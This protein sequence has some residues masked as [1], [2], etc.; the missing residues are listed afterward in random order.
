MNQYV[1]EQIIGRGA[2]GT[3]FLCSD[4]AR[5]NRQCI[6]KEIPME[7]VT[8]EERSTALNE[9]QILKVLNHPNIVRYI[10]SALESRALLIVMEYVTGGTLYDYLQRQNS[11]LSEEL[12]LNFF[13]QIAVALGHIHSKNVLHRDLKT[14]NLLIDRQ[15]RVLKISD[16][17][18][19]KVLSSKSKAMTVVG[20]PCYISPEVCDHRPYNQKS[21]IWA[22]GCILYELCTLK[23]AFEAP[24]LPALVMKIMRANYAPPPP[25]YSNNLRNIISKC[26]SLEP[27]RRPNTSQLL[28]DPMLFKTMQMLYADIGAYQPISSSK[29]PKNV[30]NSVAMNK[31]SYVR[32]SRV[33][34][35]GDGHLTPSELP[36]LS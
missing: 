28:C 36:V 34:L 15:A 16:F 23:R 26:L 6:L 27:H 11:P 5:Q 33:Y 21:D 17:G 9:V 32:G 4:K 3:V 2:Y 25:I 18:I 35:W 19:S 14:Q 8:P 31:P 24:S 12:V 29:R 30:T 20:T 13:V 10:D 1:K 22:I 7:Q